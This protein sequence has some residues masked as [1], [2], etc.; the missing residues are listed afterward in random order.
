MHVHIAVS[1]SK[2]TTETYTDSSGLPV[3]VRTKRQENVT[4]NSSQNYSR[5]FNIFAIDHFNDIRRF[6]FVFI[7]YNDYY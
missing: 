2:H 3:G 6:I 4:D 7:A 5:C 1:R